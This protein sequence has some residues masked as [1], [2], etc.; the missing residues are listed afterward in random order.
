M[1][2]LGT[3]GLQRRGDLSAN[4]VFMFKI[5]VLMLQKGHSILQNN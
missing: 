5:E 2:G 1:L 4:I 3:V